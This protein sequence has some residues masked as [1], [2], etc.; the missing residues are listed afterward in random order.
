MNNAQQSNA[1]YPVM[2][3]FMWHNQVVAAV[4]ILVLNQSLL[5]DT[6]TIISTWVLDVSRAM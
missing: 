6:K 5:C 2:S 3:V 1:I 4:I